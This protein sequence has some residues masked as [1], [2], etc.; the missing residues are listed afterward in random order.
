MSAIKGGYNS[1][2]RRAQKMQSQLT[3][4]NET[5]ADRIVES[6]VGG[7]SVKLSMNGNREV[8]SLEIDPA[9]ADPDDLESLQDLLIAAFNETIQNVQDMI[10]AETSKLTGGINMPWM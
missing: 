4:L 1:I 5:L 9:V 7:G 2:V 8:V 3:K 10:D 6:Q